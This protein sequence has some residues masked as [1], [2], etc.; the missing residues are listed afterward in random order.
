MA[1][2]RMRV[3]CKD[4]LICDFAQYYHIYDIFA[5]DLKTA[6]TLACGL[7]AESRTVMQIT[8][9][10]FSMADTLM[11]A[12]LD[13]LRSI[14]YSYVSVHSKRKVQKP[15]P[16]SQMLNQKDDNDIAIFNSAE[17]FEAERNRLLRGNRNGR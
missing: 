15:Q 1:Y 4:A 9:Q 5:L 2:A 16:L 10:K 7:P 11:I 12:M 3:I 14:E 17:E 8:G 13:T 6:A